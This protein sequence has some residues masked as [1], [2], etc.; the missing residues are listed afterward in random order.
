MYWILTNTVNDNQVNRFHF[1]LSRW[2]TKYKERSHILSEYLLLDNVKLMPSGLLKDFEY[3]I[4]ISSSPQAKPSP[5]RPSLQHKTDIHSRSLNTIWYLNLI[6]FDPPCPSSLSLPDTVLVLFVETCFYSGGDC[7]ES[8]ECGFHVADCLSAYVQV[9]LTSQ[10]YS[11]HAGFNE[12]SLTASWGKYLT[13]I[14]LKFC[15]NFYKLS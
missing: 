3:E 5:S 12:L 1:Q 13:N 7:G 14:Q 15:L 4:N 6:I 9:L 10:L 8:Q 2:D 11:R